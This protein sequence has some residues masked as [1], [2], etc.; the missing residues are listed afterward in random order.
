MIR[1]LATYGG[2]M[3]VSNVIGPLMVVWDRFVIGAII[4]SAAVAIYVVPFNFVWQILIVP[5]AL[6]SALFPELRPGKSRRV[7]TP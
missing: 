1:G 3:T 2:W 6:T 7:T 4:G 5:A